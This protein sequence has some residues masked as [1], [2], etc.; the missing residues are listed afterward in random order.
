MKKVLW[1][2]N[3]AF[4]DVP[5]RA[6]GTWLSAMGRAVAASGEY[7]VTNISQARLRR[8]I[9]SD[10]G[11]IRQWLVPFERL[12]RDGLPSRRTVRSIQRIADEIGPDLVHVWGVENYWGLLTARRLL[13]PPALLDMQGIKHAIAPRMTGG[14][15][16]REILGCL[17]VKEVLRPRSSILA[18][19]AAFAAWRGREIEIVRGHRFVACQSDWVRAHVTAI[20]P[21]GQLFAAAIMLRPEFMDA[22]TW[23]PHGGA[24]APAIFTLASLSAPYK[25]LHVVLRATAILRAAFPGIR[26]TVCAGGMPSGFRRSGYARWL[27]REM[28]CL[29]VGDCVTFLDPLDARGLVAQMLQADAVVIPSFVESYSLALAEAMAAGTPLVV[30]YAGA[31]PELARDG[32]S[33]LFFSPGDETMCAWQ[34]RRIVASPELAR[35]LSAN[36]RCASRKRHEPGEVLGRQLETYRQVA[37]YVGE[38]Q[39]KERGPETGR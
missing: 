21:E 15:S 12:S 1:L 10:S 9:R 33:A 36:A 3:H 29:N 27:L 35:E 8:T 39:T 19:K 34:I 14:L 25:G 38:A 20:R 22:P 30:S 16:A 7:E 6:T 17:S 18:E 11:A 31:M 37:A 4:R 5:D 26:L 13:T 32:E 2:C 28:S 23:Q 24:R